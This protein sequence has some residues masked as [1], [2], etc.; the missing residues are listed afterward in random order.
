MN[1]F[2]SSWMRFKLGSKSKSRLLLSCY[3]LFLN[4]GEKLGSGQY[5]EVYKGEWFRD[6]GKT[7]GMPIAVKTLKVRKKTV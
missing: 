1:P 3:G 6:K 7:A 4:T 5:G 2:P